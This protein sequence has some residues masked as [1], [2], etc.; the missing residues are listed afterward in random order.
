MVAL[1]VK[2]TLDALS[3]SR[4]GAIDH[5]AGRVCTR[6]AGQVARVRPARVRTD[7]RDA[8]IIA[9]QLSSVESGDL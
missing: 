2:G 3:E 8:T 9:P 1:S 7:G 5:L 6:G 4:K